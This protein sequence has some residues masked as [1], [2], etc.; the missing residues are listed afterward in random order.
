MHFRE[1]D[2]KGSKEKAEAIYQC[3]STGE[4]VSQYSHI[5]S[6]CEERIA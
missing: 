4:I 5:I 6:I 2:F 3:R 1:D